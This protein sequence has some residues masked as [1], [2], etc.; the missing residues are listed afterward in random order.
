M[1][2]L[3]PPEGVAVVKGI[4]SLRVM[5]F[6]K[7]GSWGWAVGKGAVG[8]EALEEQAFAEESV[9]EKIGGGGGW[10]SGWV[11]S[12]EVRRGKGVGWLMG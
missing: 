2:K 10:R 7:G 9:G 4:G 12:G 3:G 8:Q 1:G 11:G 6:G 5:G